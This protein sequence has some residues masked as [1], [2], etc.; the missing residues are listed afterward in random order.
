M[1]NRAYPPLRASPSVHPQLEELEARCLPSAAA[2]LFVAGVFEDLTG[3]PPPDAVVRV[4]SRQLD[5]RL[6]RSQLIERLASLPA[7]RP[8]LIPAGANFG[9][10]GVQMGSS[11][12]IGLGVQVSGCGSMLNWVPTPASTAKRSG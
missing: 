10:V 4:W 9:G 3:R 1:F 7:L 5:H 2:R 12:G 8:K 11:P 6:N